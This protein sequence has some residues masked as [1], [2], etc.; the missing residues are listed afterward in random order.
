MKALYHNRRA[1]TFGILTKKMADR[2]SMATKA[3]KEKEQA[4]TNVQVAVRCRPPNEEERKTGQPTV[5]TCD[6]SNKQLNIA[7]GPAGKKITKAFNF[8][9][10]FGMYSTQSEVFDG[11]V[12]PIVDEVLA[13]FNCTIFAYGQTGTGKT[14][15]MEG[16]VNN[17]ENAG[18][19]PR[20]VRAI[21]EQLENSGCEFTVRV[22]F[23]ELYNE[24][25]QDLLA[26]DKSKQLKLCADDTKG[27]VCQNLEEVNVVSVNAIFEIL[28]RG[29]KER[30]TAA[31]LMN[32]NSS[33]SHSIFTMKIMIKVYMKAYIC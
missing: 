16:E 21:F 15:T 22:S 25:L 12:K 18:I 8:D 13:G 20:S 33:R 29:I 27:V 31:T 28:Q 1:R 19:V 32:K 30:Q 9:K 24:E 26:I 4:S 23:L 3:S 5:V 7:Y 11:I 6:S 14:H 2:A 10:V 17:E